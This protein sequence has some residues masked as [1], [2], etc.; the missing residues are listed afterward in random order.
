MKFGCLTLLVLSHCC[1]AA[2]AE[3]KTTAYTGATIHTAAGKTFEPGTL[4]VR[5]GRIV[6]VGPGDAVAVPDDAVRVD[7]AGKV[8]IPGLVDSHSHLG[9]S[10]RPGV[11]ANYDGNEATGPVQSVVRALDAI[12]P[13]DPGLRMAQ[14]GGVTTA[15]IMPGSGNVIGG[16]TLYVKL[17]GHTVEQMAIVSP[18]VLGGLKMANG[19]NPKR[20]YGSRNQAPI[21]RMKIAA[22]QRGEFLK[23]RDY[24]RKWDT[25]RKKLAA[26][27]DASPPDVDLNLEPLVEVLQRKRTVHF[28]THRSDDIMTVLRLAEEFGFELVVQ[29]GTEAYKVADELARRNVP[30]SMTLPE[31]P[32]GK[33]EVAELVEE[34]GALLAA[35]GVKVLVN[36]DDPITESRFFLRTA[37]IA[38]RGG[39]D[40]DTALK[41]ITLHPAQ[42]MHVDGRVG[43]LEKGKDADFVVLSGEPFS[44]YTRVLA[45]YIDGQMVFDLADP[46]DRLYQTGGFAVAE[47]SQM[48]AAGLLVAPPPAP[49]AEPEPPA[50]AERPTAESSEF[51]VLAGRLHT[52]A[53]EAVDNGAVY[54]RDGKI[55]Y[56]GPRQGFELPKG[57]LVL[58]AAAVTPG[59]IDA[60]SVVPLNGAYNIPADQD[61]DEKS[62]TN[63]AELRAL[64]AFNPHE[65]LLRFLLE[66]GVTVIH[67]CP[68][69]ANVIAGQTGVFRTHGATAEAMAVRFPQMMLFNLGEYPK[70]AYHD[71]RPDTRMGTAAVAR[72]ALADAGNYARKRRATKDEASQPD[73]NLKHEALGQLL[74]QKLPAMFCAQ[75]A[76]DIV[77]ALRLVD[78]FKLKGRLALSAEAYLM[79]DRLAEAKLPVIV[80]PT[81]Q[82]VAEMETYHSFLGNAAALADRG[83]LVA[84]G[85]GFENYVPK[86]RVVR[87]EA[88][89]AMVHGLGFDR[90]LR[91]ITLDA[92]RILEIDDRFGTLEAGKAADLVLY[93]GDPFEYATH[94]TAVVVDGKLVHDRATRPKVPLE[95]R[96]MFFNPDPRCCLGW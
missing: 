67:A 70:E 38:V 11:T 53:A 64:D 58:T 44:V 81:M 5:Q 82:R 73:R 66:Q 13:F 79:T 17:R 85:S 24:Q 1:I 48:P 93:D 69:R 54:V 51:V 65:P 62:D 90:A 43:S 45:T 35:A 40:R 74:E 86:T 76:D 7:L 31:S 63:Q 91:A 42:A 20:N 52:V 3:P 55:V 16:Q 25:F 27:Q 4:V 37:A 50:G 57:V 2:G 95:Q 12:N 34:T 77:T 60:H 41:T 33:A 26:G 46:K 21:T 19:E 8:I 78:E 47:A 23:A 22:M 75:R 71:R 87:Y 80:H 18:D 94:V 30:V 10:S 83:I 56:A 14:A 89:M 15:N 88:A 84:V 36:T 92:A 72:A 32:G 6:D 49:A 29:H 61:A 39:L 59:L 96:L 68:G 28:H 9:V